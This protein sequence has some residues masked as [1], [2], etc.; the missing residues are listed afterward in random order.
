MEILAEIRMLSQAVLLIWLRY[1][2]WLRLDLSVKFHH[3]VDFKD[4]SIT[5]SL[6]TD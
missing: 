1:S 4:I 6:D 5:P 3:E 2:G